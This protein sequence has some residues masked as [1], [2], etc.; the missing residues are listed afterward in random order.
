MLSD[1]KGPLQLPIFI[2]TEYQHRYSDL[3]KISQ[4]HLILVSVF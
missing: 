2:Y 1:F 4:I 3:L